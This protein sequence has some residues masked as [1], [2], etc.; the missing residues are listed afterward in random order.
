M[1]SS[2]LREPQVD[3]AEPV[4]ALFVSAFGTGRQVDAEEIR[5]WLDNTEFE[6]GWFRVLVEDGRIAGYGDIWPQDADLALDVAAPGKWDVFLDWAES[7][8]RSRRIPRIR[9]TP[10]AGHELAGAC[11]ARGYRL[12]RSSLTMEI[13]LDAAAEPAPVDGFELSAY[14]DADQEQLIAALNESFARDP[15][16][17]TISESNFREFYLRAR[18]FDPSLWTLAW[19]GDELA[20]FSLAYYRHGA[21]D[22]L[23]WVGTLGV[24]ESW[25]RRGLGETL[26]RTAFARLYDR[27]LRR[28][29]LGVDSENV[30]GAVGLYERAGMSNVARTDNWVL[31][32]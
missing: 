3:D 14:R 19:A 27:G 28:V 20:G 7:E 12:W 2:Q 17:H 11:E 31:E 26:L 10:P 1:S 21:D 30:T 22:T 9:T 25:R 24:R 6:P 23:G 15:F 8:A 4:A 29:G 13:E 5:S 16:W 18:G 32:L